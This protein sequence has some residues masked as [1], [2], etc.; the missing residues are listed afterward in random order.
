MENE[1]KS[2]KEA[3]RKKEATEKKG[4]RQRRGR[5]VP[6][7]WWPYGIGLMLARVALRMQRRCSC[8][9]E[10]TLFHY[11]FCCLYVQSTLV[12]GMCLKTW[13]M[14]VV[15]NIMYLFIYFDVYNYV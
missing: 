9:K 3:T 6:R 8:S 2:M 1:L 7:T 13:W 11:I 12:D 4:R 5:R 14:M 15:G 10:M